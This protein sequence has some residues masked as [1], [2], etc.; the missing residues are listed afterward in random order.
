MM[1]GKAIWKPGITEIAKPHKEDLKCPLEP[2]AARANV[3]TH[4]GLW[5]TNIKLNPS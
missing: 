4:I 5:P 2:K 3:L 1:H